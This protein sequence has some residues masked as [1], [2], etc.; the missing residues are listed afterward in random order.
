MSIEEAHK[1]QELMKQA[2]H[3]LWNG[4]H[5]A[6]ST[7]GEM[8]IEMEKDK[9]YK[10][11]GYKTMDD[12]IVGALNQ[13][14]STVY[15]MMNY[16]RHITPLL[17]DNPK[18]L[19]FPVTT[20]VKDII[21]MI[22]KDNSCI[23]RICEMSDLSESDRKIEMRKLVNPHQTECEHNGETESFVKCLDCGRLIKL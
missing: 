13:S 5:H 20:L 6:Y 14:K 4:N 9:K 2:F 12:F 8:A 22:K 3:A 18:L 23:S 7:I 17:P 16:R 1:L 15:G 19:E 11:I 10:D 21:P